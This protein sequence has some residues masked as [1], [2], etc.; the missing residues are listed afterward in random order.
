MKKKA[1]KI[2]QNTLCPCGSGKKYKNCS[3]NKKM[4]VSIKEEYKRRYD[5]YLK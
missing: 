4:E 5:I 1:V 2:G 3:R